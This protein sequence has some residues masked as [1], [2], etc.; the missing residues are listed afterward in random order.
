MSPPDPDNISVQS[1]LGERVV[2][3]IAQA[4]LLLSLLF[5]CLLLETVA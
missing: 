3:L 5:F 2:S 4:T 1:G